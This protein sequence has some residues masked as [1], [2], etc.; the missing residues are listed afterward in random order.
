MAT[1][2]LVIPGQ[3]YLSAFVVNVDKHQFCYQSQTI[4]VFQLS[5]FIN[6]FMQNIQCFY[7]CAQRSVNLCRVQTGLYFLLI[8]VAAKERCGK[9]NRREGMGC[10]A[11]IR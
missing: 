10:M 4:A 1:V 11:H 2:P 8:L 7:F 3:C 9:G 5:C 6:S